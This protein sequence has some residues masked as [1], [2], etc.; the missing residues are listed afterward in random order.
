MH[1]YGNL[2]SILS[3][4]E[5]KWRLYTEMKCVHR[6]RATT[7]FAVHQVMSM[8]PGYSSVQAPENM[9]YAVHNRNSAEPCENHTATAT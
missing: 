3:G 8:L 2:T 6:V 4:Y 9:V 1:P 7:F 5:G